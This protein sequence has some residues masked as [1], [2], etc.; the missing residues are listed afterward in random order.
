LHGHH[1]ELR[2]LLGARTV[3]A[4]SSS[5]FRRM[6][7]HNRPNPLL[8]VDGFDAGRSTGFH[9]IEDKTDVD[10]PPDKP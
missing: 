3:V 5:M 1:P 10:F 4:F 7:N 8:S 9:L 2:A 6:T